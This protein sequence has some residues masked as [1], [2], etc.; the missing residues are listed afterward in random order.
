MILLPGPLIAILT[1]PGVIVHEIGHRIFADWAKI[2][3]YKIC[4][5]RIGSPAGY[6]IH[7]SPKG[8]KEAVFVSVGPLI[9]NT[10][11][12]ALFTFP[13]VFPFYLLQ[14]TK[15][16]FV[17]IFLAWLGFSIGMH[18]FPSNQ[19]MNNLVNA[20]KKTNQDGWFLL[21]AKFFAKF[22]MI[23]NGLR[24]IWFDA[25]YALGIALLLPW[26]FGFI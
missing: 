6:V 3:I 18:A 17:F 5:F 10:L 24:F 25:I 14:S 11:L 4:Y 23:A 20:V 19:D 21:I 1:F 15:N 7:G 13:A 9:V 8:L 16:N 12:C 26:L 2:P 22:F